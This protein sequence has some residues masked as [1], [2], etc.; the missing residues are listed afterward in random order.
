MYQIV[1]APNNT[2]GIP[3]AREVIRATLPSSVR[4][5]GVLAAVRYD[6]VGTNH[7]GPA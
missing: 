7:I 1:I 6:E 4:E 3:T 2:A 5:G